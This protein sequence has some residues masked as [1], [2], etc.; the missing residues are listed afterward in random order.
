M[1]N[2]INIASIVYLSLKYKTAIALFSNDS[3]SIA[4]NNVQCTVYT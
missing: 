1:F 3:A 2:F 4:Y